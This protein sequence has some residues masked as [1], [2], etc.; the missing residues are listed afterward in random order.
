MII[1]FDVT[2]LAPER[3][4]LIAVLYEE[5]SVQL[6]IFEDEEEIEEACEAFVIAHDKRLH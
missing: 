2:I 4:L 3:L 5:P 6:G 1:S